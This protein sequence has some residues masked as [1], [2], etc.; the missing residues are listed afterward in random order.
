MAGLIRLSTDSF[1][2][3][4]LHLVSAAV[5]F[6]L[7]LYTSHRDRPKESR[8]YFE[9][10]VDGILLYPFILN[11]RN[12]CIES[13]PSFKDEFRVACNSFLKKNDVVST[14][15][16]YLLRSE[17]SIF[18]KACEYGGGR[19]PR[20]RG[21]FGETHVDARCKWTASSLRME[22]LP[23]TSRWPSTRAWCLGTRRWWENV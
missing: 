10:A 15:Y 14:R 8:L 1:E 11:L 13:D 2:L 18:Q 5:T 20:G 6:L 9:R 17:G 23:P 16:R 4:P 19:W 3:V 7:A 22:W 12:R 21:G